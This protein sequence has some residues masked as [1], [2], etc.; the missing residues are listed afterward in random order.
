MIKNPSKGKFA[1]YLGPPLAL[2]VFVVIVPVFGALY[3][4]FF[5]WSGGPRMTFTGLDNYVTLLSD[6][7]FWK[8]FYNNIVLTVLCVIGQI[9][10]ALLLALML[11]SRHMKMKGFH[12][13]VAYFPVILSAVVVGYIWSMLY[14][15]RHGLINTILALLGM[16]DKAQAWLSN[17]DLALILTAIPLIWKNIG[18]YLIIILSGL[19]SIDTSILEMAEIDGANA[20]R[21]LKSITFPMLRAT[22][23]VC[24]TLCI[25]GNMK[26]FDH[27]YVMTGGGPGTATMV[28]ALYAYEN[29]FIRYKMGYGSTISIGILVLSIA[30]TQIVRKATSLKKEDA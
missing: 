14:D 9:G 6:A 29:S 22:L 27:I 30:I 10:I 5:N 26:V 4:S 20:W 16:E 15:Y 23:I 18:Y 24:L 7:T 28:M 17:P 21:K 12:I 8:S 3:Y 1:I 25:S 13:T 11:N 19:A 2:F